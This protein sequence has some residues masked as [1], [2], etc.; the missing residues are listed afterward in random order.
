MLAE[1]L[2]V[3]ILL[4]V[5]VFFSS[6]GFDPFIVTI[7]IAFFA[8]VIFTIGW[9]RVALLRGLKKGKGRGPYKRGRWIIWLMVLF[10]GATFVALSWE[11]ALTKYALAF[12]TTLFCLFLIYIATMIGDV[13]IGDITNFFI[14][15]LSV[16]I[17]MFWYQFYPLL[18]PFFGLRIHLIPLQF[19]ASGNLIGGSVDAIYLAIACLI[20]A[21]TADHWAPMV[22][23]VLR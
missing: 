15:I 10:T 5:L 9:E 8:T 12:L 16:F 1:L 23:R 13:K 17:F 11:G 19:D 20:M 3:A 14:G 7:F 6:A 4:M 2:I 18:T 22:R 21:F